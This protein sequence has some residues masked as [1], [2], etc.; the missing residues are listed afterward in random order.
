MKNKKVITKLVLPKNKPVN[1]K[2]TEL[3]P[4]KNTTVFN[5]FLMVVIIVLL[6]AVVLLG[7]IHVNR[8]KK[9]DSHLDKWNGLSEVVYITNRVVVTNTDYQFYPLTEIYLG[10][11]QDL[12]LSEPQSDYQ[13]YPHQHVKHHNTVYRTHF[14]HHWFTPYQYSES[15]HTPPKMETGRRAHFPQRF[16]RFSPINIHAFHGKTK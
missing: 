3:V 15:K 14:R 16:D 7:R 10:K 4:A 12:Y 13:F 6:S 2:L 5:S 8:Q 11:P 1:S 9:I